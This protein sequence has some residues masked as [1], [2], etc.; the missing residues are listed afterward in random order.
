M[1]NS[2]LLA[3]ILPK[4]EVYCK[5]ALAFCP[6][7]DISIYLTLNTTSLQSLKFKPAFYLSLLISIQCLI[8]SVYHEFLSLFIETTTYMQGAWLK[9]S[10]FCLDH[11]STL[12]MLLAYFLLISICMLT[13]CQ[14]FYSTKAT[15]KFL[16]LKSL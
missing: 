13:F 16:N 11:F 15:K 1:I 7:F 9:Y 6:G 3:Q 5:Q 10:F 12:S 2:F 14:F 4:P 8:N